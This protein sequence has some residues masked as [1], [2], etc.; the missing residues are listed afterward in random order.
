VLPEASV[1][2]LD[3]G[4]VALVILEP[5]PLKDA[6]TECIVDVLFEKGPDFPLPPTLVL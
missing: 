4:I 1:E 3:S 2:G 6:R 5:Q